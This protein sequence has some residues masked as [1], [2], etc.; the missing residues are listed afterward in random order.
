MNKTDVDAP[1]H[2]C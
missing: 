2:D 1:N